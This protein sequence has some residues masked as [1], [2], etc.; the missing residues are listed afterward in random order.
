[1]VKGQQSLEMRRKWTGSIQLRA[2]WL[3][4]EW[5]IRLREYQTGL[6][7]PGRWWGRKRRQWGIRSGGTVSSAE[8]PPSHTQWYSPFPSRPPNALRRKRSLPDFTL[9][10]SDLHWIHR[11]MRPR[12][13]PTSG[14]LINVEKSTS[15]LTSDVVLCARKS[16]R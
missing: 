8:T 15:D 13:V 11:D 4:V 16:D 3:K 7:S 12:S 6:S 1:M 2:R 5:D 14:T 10:R 9:P